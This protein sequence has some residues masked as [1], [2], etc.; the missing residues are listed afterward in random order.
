M[1][2][3]FNAVLLLFFNI[4]VI[5][6]FNS[7]LGPIPPLGKLLNPF[8]GLWQNEKDSLRK[9]NFSSNSNLI[10]TGAKIRY[11]KNLVPHIFSSNDSDA[12]FALGYVIAR[13]RL[14]QMDFTSRAIT[15]RMSE[16]FGKNNTIF[17]YVIDY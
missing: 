11:D 2:R 7:K 8:Y 13:E 14:W 15:G 5:Y 12:F 6:L 16:I 3:T 1:N 17:E 10:I 9:K 4:F